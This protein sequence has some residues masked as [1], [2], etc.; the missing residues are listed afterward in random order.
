[1][2]RDIIQVTE[3]A[4]DHIRAIV[5]KGQAENMGY[6]GLRV[7]IKKG[8]CSGSEYD[9]Q[10]AEEKAPYEEEI[11]TQGVKLF[12]DPA[13]TLKLIGS[14]MDYQEDDFSEGFVFTNPNEMGSCGCGKSVKL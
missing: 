10:Y 8:G 11:E 2:Q 3:R 9:F 7:G 13:A 4:A 14:V 12:I 6:V 5:E 1:M